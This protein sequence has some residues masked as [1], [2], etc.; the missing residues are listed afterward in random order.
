MSRLFVE[1]RIFVGTISGG[2]VIPL[3]AGL[4]A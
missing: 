3:P 1:L 4:G 2:T